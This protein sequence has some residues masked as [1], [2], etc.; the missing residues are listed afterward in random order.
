MNSSDGEM[1]NVVGI[2]DPRHSNLYPTL[3]SDA[4]STILVY[5]ELKFVKSQLSPAN[6][7]SV[8]GQFIISVFFF[9]FDVF[10]C[11]DCNC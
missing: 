8:Q 5:F 7:A 9:E 10:V 11:L 3:H 2:M 4:F 6:S 1:R